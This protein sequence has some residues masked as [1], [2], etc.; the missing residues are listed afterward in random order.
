MM[1]RR[2]EESFEILTTINSESTTQVEQSE[3]KDDECQRENL[4][5]VKI[6]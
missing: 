1:K 5:T 2:V 6:F 3:T 4:R